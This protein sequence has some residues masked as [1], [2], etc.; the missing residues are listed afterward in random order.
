MQKPKNFILIILL[1]LCL[2]PYCSHPNENEQ[3][4]YQTSTINALLE[5]CYNGD[6]TFSQLKQK[7]NFGIGT[8]N[9]LDGEMIAFEGEFYQV[10]SDGNVYKVSDTMKTPFAAV[11]NFNPDWSF[12]INDTLNYKQLS[13]FLDSV[14]PSQ[15]II[16]GIKINGEFNM[17]KTRSV[18]KQIAPFKPLVEVVANQ[19]VFSF[20]NTKGTLIGFRIP[21]YMKGV[22]VPGYHFHF[23]TE[24]KGKGGHLLDCSGINATVSIDSIHHFQL[25][26]PNNKD[27]YK[28]ELGKDKKEELEMVEK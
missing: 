20:K 22:N 5:G 28:L 19:P 25:S 8:F 16:Y 10:K 12:T 2:F 1:T 13:N 23:I 3:V 9:S 18:P 27:F 21:E 26:L 6:V 17:V 14:L 7:G 24:D 11:V 4:L 15:N